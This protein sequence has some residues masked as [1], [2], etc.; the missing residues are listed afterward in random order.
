MNVA[1]GPEHTVYTAEDDTGR[2]K[3]YSEDGKLLGLV[4]SVEMKP[5]CKNCSISVSKDGSRVYM[6]DITRNFIVRMDAR[7]AEEVAADIKNAPAAAAREKNSVGSILEWI[8]AALPSN[9]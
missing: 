8:Q 1:F 6:L 4:G 7:P 5:G 9:N 2:I 3:R